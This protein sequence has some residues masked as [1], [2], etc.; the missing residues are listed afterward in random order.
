MANDSFLSKASMVL[1][2]RC[3]RCDDTE[4]RRYR[5]KRRRTRTTRAGRGPW[6]WGVDGEVAS[7]PPQLGVH[8]STDDCAFLTWIPQATAISDSV[9]AVL[10][11]SVS[12]F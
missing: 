6:K 1:S 3:G 7:D 4:G 11:R 5:S 9:D 8:A 2:W 10:I 12:S